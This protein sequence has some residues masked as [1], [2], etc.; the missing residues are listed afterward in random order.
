M[1]TRSPLPETAMSPGTRNTKGTRLHGRW[2]VM[3]RVVWVAV[4]VLTLSIF[5]ASLPAYFA[6]LQTVCADVTCVYSY[7]LLT[8]GTAQA[9]HNLGLST[10]GYALS[11]FALAIAST[12]VSF[13]VAT[14][15]FWRRSDD[16]MAMF[17]SLF[18]VTFGVNFIVQT[19]AI[20]ATNV[21]TA[22]YWLLNILIG[23]GWVSLSLLLCLFPD[24]KFVPRWTRAL[25]VFVVANTLLLNAFPVSISTFTSWM[26]SAIYLINGG[27]GIVAQIYRYARVSG[28]VQRQQTKWVVFGLAATTVVILGRLVPLLIF[29]SLSAS[30]SP[31]FLLSTYVYPLG[32]LLIPL[33]L[34]IA[35]L[36][37]RLWDIDILINR[38]LVYGT[39][40]AL[41]AM[42][43]VG[44]VIGLQLLV[45][46][47]TGQSGQSPVVIVASTLA[48]VALFQPLRGRIQMIIDRR[49]YH[50][51]Y[52]AARTLAAFSA[53]LRDEVDL[54]QLSEH[55]LAVVEETM[56]P[57]SV[58]LWLFPS[59][60]ERRPGTNQ[61][62]HLN[63][64]SGRD[65]T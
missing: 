25:A 28:P 4:V 41:L 7:G 63:E 40:T 27:S 8:P 18:L 54:S 1:H 10:G 6:Q 65:E 58:S 61:L 16:W 15:I 23:L 9:L 55:L 64:V 36:R 22:W 37:Y 47:F 34:G 57:A 19:Q 59:R 13:G 53:T 29:P 52:D 20:L 26:L 46:L 45:R 39:L 21:Q 56:Q 42:V 30:S 38:T 17:V 3:A 14:L 11:V 43:Y 60:Q 32:L 2:L 24:G 62:P 44:L 12:L 49:F 33:T 35:I 51:K 50:R 5:I 31:Y 48:I